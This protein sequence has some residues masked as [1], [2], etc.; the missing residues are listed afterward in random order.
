MPRPPVT[1]K[2]EAPLPQG[3]PR[4]APPQ[5]RVAP[6]VAGYEVVRMLGKG[7]MGVVWEAFEHRLERRVALKVHSG[8]ATPERVAKL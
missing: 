4:A 2:I 8:G 7:G 5:A 1:A 3:A 6:T